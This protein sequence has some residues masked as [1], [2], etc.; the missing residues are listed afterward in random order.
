MKAELYPLVGAEDVVL[1]CRAAITSRQ[2]LLLYPAWSRLPQGDWQPLPRGC[3]KRLCISNFPNDVVESLFDAVI[4]GALETNEERDLLKAQVNCKVPYNQEHLSL[5]PVT[6]NNEASFIK[7][8]QKYENCIHRIMFRSCPLSMFKTD[9]HY[10]I[11][12]LDGTEVGPFYAVPNAGYVEFV[13]VLRLDEGRGYV[14]L[15]GS[16]CLVSSKVLV[17]DQEGNNL[18]EKA[19]RDGNVDMMH[20]L[21]ADMPNIDIGKS[22]KQKSTSAPKIKEVSVSIPNSVEREINEASSV[23]KEHSK[24]SRKAPAPVVNYVVKTIKNIRV[25]LLR[26]M[27]GL[28]FMGAGRGYNL[29]CSETAQRTGT[30]RGCC[31]FDVPLAKLEHPA[32][33]GEKWFFDMYVENMR[34]TYSV[35]VEQLRKL[36]TNRKRCKTVY[37]NVYTEAVHD[38]DGDWIGAYMQ[39]E[40]TD[41]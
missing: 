23:K 17:L 35:P 34:T 20:A 38:G 9:V 14:K 40:E 30:Y 1:R 15:N 31:W 5:K 2:E 24:S 37:I 33:D 32:L 19:T 25:S 10:F 3:A 22:K 41:W 18:Y 13:P 4:T 7:I 12:Y 29:C 21:L 39:R 6:L 26:S 28:H 16:C 11:K 36:P 27:R 8:Q